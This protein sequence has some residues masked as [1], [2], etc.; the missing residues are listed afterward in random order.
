MEKENSN[1]QMKRN[2]I[3]TKIMNSVL[4]VVLKND[5]VN[6]FHSSWTQNHPRAVSSTSFQ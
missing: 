2:K 4:C 3:K 5:I 1:L 6:L